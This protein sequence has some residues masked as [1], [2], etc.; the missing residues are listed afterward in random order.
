MATRT[1]S[2]LDAAAHRAPPCPVSCYFSRLISNAW[3][4]AFW[5]PAQPNVGIT[6]VNQAEHSSTRAIMH[7]RLLR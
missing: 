1:R 6:H 4:T 2:K 3:K 7:G 5:K